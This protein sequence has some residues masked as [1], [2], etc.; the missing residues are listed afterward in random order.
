M[1]ETE[2]VEAPWYFSE[3]WKGHTQNGFMALESVGWRRG[4][5]MELLSCGWPPLVT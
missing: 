4:H 1:M 5:W 3:S 2:G